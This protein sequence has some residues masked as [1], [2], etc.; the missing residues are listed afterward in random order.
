MDDVISSRVYRIV[1]WTT[2]NVGERSVR[3]VVANPNLEIVGC[4]AWG[5]DKVGR[6]VGELVGIDPIGV[7]ATADID[8]LLALKP[9]CV[10]YNPK[11]PDVDHLVRI[12]E[13]GINVTATAGF[14]TGHALGDGRDRIIAACER[15]GSSIFGS[16]M[17]PGLANLLGIVSAGLCDRIDS[18][19]VLESVDSTGYDSEDTERSVG[20]G[21]AID[22]P[23]LPALVAAGTAVF[24]DAV[25]LLGDALGVAF[26]EVRCEAEFAQTTE[27]LDMGSWAIEAGCVAGVAA[28]WQGWLDG[29]KIVSLDVRWRKGRTL[30]PD[31]K[32]EHGYV[33][34]VQGMPSVR[35]KLEVFPPADFVAESFSDYMVLGMIMTAMPAVNAV[36]SVCAAKPGI[37]TYL[38]MALP[39]PS[40]W[41][42][43]A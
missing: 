28:S 37:V 39:R 33:V 24:G 26:D 21:R 40:G 29:R 25:H 13:S 14:I 41:V 42:N 8:A 5:A 2:G 16:G 34:E 11:W 15:G 9:D 10:I 7:T 18:V 31:W 3:A 22:D 23:E 19:R 17:N 6:D 4:Y 20:H 32:V 1:Q 43:G 38:D 12:L 30:E 27:R 36:A 35:T